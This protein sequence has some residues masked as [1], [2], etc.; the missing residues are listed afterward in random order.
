MIKNIKI[1]FNTYRSDL[2]IFSKYS[3]F[4]SLYRVLAIA[5]FPLVKKFKPNLISV[6][7]LLLGIVAL[8]LSLISNTIN[9]SHLMF[10]FL[11]SFILDFS[12][13]MV[14]RFHN[15]SSFHGRFMD[16]LFDLVVF[17]LLH[18]IFFEK[19]INEN[20]NFFH[21]YFYLITI[22]LFPIQHLIMD[23]Y[24]AIARWINEI[25]N[26]KFKKPY[27]INIFLGKFTM[28]LYD[29]QHLCIWLLIIDK[30][31]YNYI[32]DAFFII[33]FFASIAS[34]GIY[35]YLSN[36]HFSSASNQ[37]DNDE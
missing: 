19:I 10:Y 28:L 17:G 11:F 2:F 34:F 27:Y 20:N 23:R 24:S 6:A 21:P 7:S 32:V 35:L 3:F 18:I 16:G 5:I 15:K 22:L 13:G 1:L 31:S 30:L 25:N 33:S 36:K 9:L 37:T 26:K 12:D 29:F 8:F 14:A 4:E